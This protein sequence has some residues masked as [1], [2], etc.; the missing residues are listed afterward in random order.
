VAALIPGAVVALISAAGAGLAPGAAAR[1]P[2]GAAGLTPGSATPVRVGPAG[3]AAVGGAAPVPG[4]ATALPTGGATGSATTSVATARTW[5]WLGSCGKTQLALS[6]AESLWQSGDADLL[7]WVTATS[8]ASV[9]S[10]YAEVAADAMGTGPPGEAESVAARFLSWLAGTSRPWIVVLDDLSDAAV[11]DGLWPAGPM[12]RVLVTAADYTALPSA[13]RLQVLPIGPFSRREALSYLHARF[14]G[15][16]DQRIGAVD[17]VADLGYEPLAL[18]QASAVVASSELTCRDYHDHF[19]ERRERLA[20][21]IGSEPPAASV[22]WTFAVEQADRLAPGGAAQSLL[23]L[24]A[25]LDGTGIPSAVFTTAAAGK[26]FES[27]NVTVPSS[28]VAPGSPVGPGR[29]G[30]ALLVLARTGLLSADLA[31]TSPMIRMSPA[32]QAAIR[33]AMPPGMLDQ[34]AKAAADALTEAWP[35]DDLPSWLATSL[36]SC[37]ASLQQVAGD[38]LWAAGCHPLLMRAGQSLDSARLT[39]PALTY[40]RDLAGISGKVLGRD[41][42]DTVAAGQRLAD[43]YLNAGQAAE[44]VSW[45]QWVLGD[46]VRALGPEHPDT[47]LARRKLGHALVTASQLGDAVNV[48]AGIVGD[49]ERALGADHIETVSA[50]EDLAAAYRAAGQ[51]TDAVRMYVRTLSDRE[52]VQGARH[53]DAIS[54]R[55]RLAEAYAASGKL[56]DAISHYKR[57]VAD[58]ERLLGY[59]H[60]DTVAA[61]ATLASA[62][63][64]A[65][66]MALALQLYEQT[67]AGYERARGVDH[68]DALA[69]CVN[70]AHAYYAVGRLSDATT[71]LRETVTRCDRVLPP[72]DPLTESARSSL[73]NIA[74]S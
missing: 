9:L 13:H 57:V 64:S 40:W 31:G 39:G 5:D 50:R 45:F 21:E 71:L 7:A 46:R 66:R 12:G 72:G 6:A 69:Q 37:A 18:A 61:R 42:P 33:A 44:A 35:A 15:S 47:I 68:P 2:G 49:Y 1:I 70:L 20:K 38:L 48:L 52:R 29:A 41:H 27:G 22:T 65:G 28:A 58:R 26:Y 10:G 16:P 8:R 14:A 3:L 59:D 62:Y 51:H 55:Q 34:A 30:E 60:V 67:R 17:L 53:P 32:V 63:H 23:V 56:K 54:T 4:S 24:A 11:L 19:L 74:G 43:A 25:L 36:R 73:A